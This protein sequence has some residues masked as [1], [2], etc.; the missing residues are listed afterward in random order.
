MQ[1][2]NSICFSSL[3]SR[4]LEMPSSFDRTFELGL[5]P[6]SCT[7]MFAALWIRLVAIF[8][9]SGTITVTDASF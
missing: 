6:G 1:A 8:P 9:L 5:V 4:R 7:S 2:H 3:K